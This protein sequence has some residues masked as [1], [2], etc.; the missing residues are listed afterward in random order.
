MS[1]PNAPV[2]LGL[3]LSFA[4]AGGVKAQQPTPGSSASPV[5]PSKAQVNAGSEELLLQV[6]INGVSQP[7]TKLML[8]DPDGQLWV[9]ESDLREWRINMPA[10]EPRVI[11]GVAYRRLSELPGATA[12]IN[13]RALQVA[14][15]IPPTAFDA[16]TLSGA[17]RL[18][19]PAVRPAF[20]AFLSYDLLAEQYSGRTT[21]SG[22]L[23]LGVFSPYGV[24]VT[25]LV[26]R[27]GYDESE[28]ARST[29][30][31]DS[32]W[33]VDFPE[34][35]TS[36]RLGDSI[37]RS[38]A[39]WGRS[40]R[41]GGIQY[42]T[43]YATRP[44]LVLLPQ[45][46]VSGS[47]VVPST[48]DV[49]VNNALVSQQSVPAG[50]FSI[51]NIPMMPGPGMMQVV[52]R[53]MLGR[54]QIIQQ[55]FF[56]TSFLLREGLNDFSFEAGA[57]RRNYGLLSSD[58]SDRFASGTW[59]RGFSNWFT[60]E[61][62]AQA[63]ERS[64]RALGLGGAVLVGNLGVVNL[65]VAASDG[66]RGQ[67]HLVGLAFNRQGRI[68][69]LGVR[70]Q[71]ASA[72]FWQL[73]LEPTERAPKLLADGFVGFSMGPWGA[74]SLGYVHQDYRDADRRPVRLATAGWSV[75]VAR[76]FFLGLNFTRSFEDDRTTTVGLFVNVPFGTYG[77]ASANTQRVKSPEG[78]QT[79]GALALQKSLPPGEGWGYR[80]RLDD[81]QNLQAGASYQ[82]NVGTY[83]L[84]VAS[85]RGDVAVRAGVQGSLVTL[86]GEF[87]AS[88]R[89]NDSFALVRVPGFPGV[90]V[91]NGN[92][93]VATTNEQ[94][95][96]I[97]PRLLAYQ[98][99]A[100]SIDE[101]DLP[102]NAKV[103]ELRQ[104]A[105]PWYRSG[106]II[107]FD[108]K[109]Q[110]DAEILLIDEAGKPLAKGGRVRLEGSN[111]PFIITAGGR[112]YVTGLAP[113]NRLI[114]DQPGSPASR[115]VVDFDFTPSND[116]LPDLGTMTCKGVTP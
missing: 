38:A 43:N 1:Q 34:R 104:T 12:A 77:N 41:F 13:P 58:Y 20:G 11:D 9:A 91:M 89:S 115:C 55:P 62:H 29:V 60:G 3:L 19:R 6:S 32:T 53:D 78:T 102:L 100:I 85:Q 87:F 30:R 2:V 96:A 93:P 15:T 73:G 21:G 17:A 116:P 74:F 103:G 86:G 68:M 108:V 97:V 75:S 18:G 84:D 24:G 92:L 114:V 65:S 26:S 23:E 36:L 64:N 51:G 40:V 70:A 112:V 80:V 22:A 94:G 59:R 105:V 90:R 66:E 69:S 5:A 28:L 61:V 8:R 33:T 79:T 109:R 37:S 7:D 48:V 44:G 71:T 107:D 50:P 4:L 101:Q 42:G 45:Q 35:I 57:L 31:L 56:G 111:E 83:S 106:V 82:N 99:N 10:A 46:A 88:R 72:E 54:E 67:G 110:L 47:A 95:V 14:L 52:V 16:T 25:G 76:L 98:N 81:A 39:G 63:S 27:A 113:K 49:F